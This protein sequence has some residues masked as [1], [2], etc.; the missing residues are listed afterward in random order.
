MERDQAVKRVLEGRRRII[1]VL[2]TRDGCV[3]KT[4]DL[5]DTWVPIGSTITEEIEIAKS[6]G[7]HYLTSVSTNDPHPTIR[8]RLVENE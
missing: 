3:D 1:K 5:G 2:S 7:G 8:N 4:E 6:L